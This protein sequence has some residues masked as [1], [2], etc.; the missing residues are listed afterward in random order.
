MARFTAAQICASVLGE[1][2]VLTNRPFV[3]SL[4]ITRLHFDPEAIRESYVAYQNSL[5]EYPWTLDPQVLR[6]LIDGQCTVEDEV[7]LLAGVGGD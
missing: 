3:E 7:E 6:R 2:R 1:P 4:D 5:E